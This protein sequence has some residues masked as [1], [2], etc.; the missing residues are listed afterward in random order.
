MEKTEQFI[1]ELG[2]FIKK[3]DSIT[4]PIYPYFEKLIEI[5]DKKQPQK[6][7]NKEVVNLSIFDPLAKFYDIDEA[8]DEVFEAFCIFLFEFLEPIQPNIF[9][10]KI[11]LFNEAIEKIKLAFKD[12]F[13]FNE[14]NTL[15][16]DDNLILDINRANCLSKSELEQDNDF[17]LDLDELHKLCREKKDRIYKRNLKSDILFLRNMFN[18]DGTY[19]EFIRNYR[20]F[21]KTSMTMLN[22]YEKIKNEYARLTDKQGIKNDFNNKMLNLCVL[23]NIDAKSTFDRSEFIND[24]ERILLMI[25][26]S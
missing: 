10:S 23:Y 8:K 11:D 19:D 24:I 15:Y 4:D 9:K 13:V 7:K 25:K 12:D 26:K 17:D 22:E 1:K 14:K 2:E 18:I 20:N 21:I 5:L 16:G 3:S 6:G